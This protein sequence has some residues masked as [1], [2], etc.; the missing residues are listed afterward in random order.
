[1]KFFNK[2][3][4]PETIEPMDLD[5][6]MKKYDRE[7]NTRIWEGTPKI[8]VNCILAIFSLF[9]IYVTL[10]ASLLEEVRLTSFMAF[11]V[12][13][14]F[15]VFPAKKGTQR[16]NYLPW[17]D[18]ILMVLGTGSFL[19]YIIFLHHEQKIKLF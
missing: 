4:A 11:I 15:L 13:M 18:I 6:V 14:G 2:K 12:F 19:Y 3:A 7:S 5:A 1:M 16:V 17:Y 10:F 9:C 8:V